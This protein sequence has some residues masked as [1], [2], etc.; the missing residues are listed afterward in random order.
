MNKVYQMDMSSILMRLIL[1]PLPSIVIQNSILMLGIA[2]YLVL[3]RKVFPPR[4]SLFNKELPIINHF[5]C[6]IYL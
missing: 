4:G 3:S 5:S 6:S 2:H 1:E